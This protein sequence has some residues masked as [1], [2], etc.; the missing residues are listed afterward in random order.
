MEVERRT[1]AT[2]DSP[3]G[4]EQAIA[5]LVKSKILAEIS[6]QVASVSNFDEASLYDKEGGGHD[7]YQSIGPT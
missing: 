2:S 3:V 6:R 4:S 1:I 7:R 5:S